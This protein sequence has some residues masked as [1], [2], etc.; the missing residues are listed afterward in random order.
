MTWEHTPSQGAGLGF[1]VSFI[2]TTPHLTAHVHSP[3]HTGRY[4]KDSTFAANLKKTTTYALFT[5][6]SLATNSQN[7]TDCHGNAAFSSSSSPVQNF[8]KQSRRSHIQYIKSPLALQSKRE[9]WLVLYKEYRIFYQKKKK[10]KRR[11]ALLGHRFCLSKDK[12]THEQTQLWYHGLAL[13]DSNSQ[14]KT[15]SRVHTV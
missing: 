2:Q 3:Y 12:S 1:L 15:H 10:K 14:D 8:S 6:T 11:H 13:Q 4:H 7:R 9:I 5:H